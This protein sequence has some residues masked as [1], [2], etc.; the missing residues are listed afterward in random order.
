MYAA[1][2]ATSDLW[3]ARNDSYSLRVTHHKSMI[4]HVQD[5]VLALQEIEARIKEIYTIS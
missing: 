1:I 3:Q 5:Q 4:V 2:H